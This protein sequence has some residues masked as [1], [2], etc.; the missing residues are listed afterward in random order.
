MSVQNHKRIAPT[1]SEYKS[2]FKKYGVPACNIAVFLGFS[3][4]YTL[5]LL[6]GIARITP[7][8]D[9]KLKDLLVQLDEA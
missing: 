7:E 1:P 3:Y 5:N 9:A 2:K 4:P 6:N 8:V